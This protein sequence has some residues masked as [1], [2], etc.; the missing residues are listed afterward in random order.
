MGNLDPSPIRKHRITRRP[1]CDERDNEHDQRERRVAGADG[2]EG[3]FGHVDENTRTAL[4][5]IVIVS[6]SL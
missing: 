1:C 4:M 3:G 5:E 6:V 2:A